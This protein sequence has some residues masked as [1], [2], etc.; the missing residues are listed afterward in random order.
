VKGCEDIYSSFDQYTEVEMLD[1]QNQYRAEG[2]GLQ[3]AQKGVSFKNFPPVLCLQLKRFEYS[4]KVDANVKLNDEYAFYPVLDLSK[5]VVEPESGTS[6]VYHLHAVL[7]HSGD[8]HGGHYYGFLRTEAKS[9]WHKFDDDHVTKATEQ[10]AIDDNF[11]GVEETELH[12]DAGRKFTNARTKFS[13]AY[14]LVYVR[15][16]DS[17]DMF[18]P[19]TQ[20]AISEHLRERFEVE[21]QLSEK[22]RKELSEA[23]LYM[24]VRLAT[25]EDFERH[26]QEKTDLVDMDTVRELRLRKS[27]TL[28]QLREKLA[29]ELNVPGERMRFWNWINRRN[30]TVRPNLPFSAAK[31]QVMLCE[32]RP[33][34][35][36]NL[37]LEVS[38]A[39]DGEPLFPPVDGHGCIFFKCFDP[40]V[41]KMR[42]LGHVCWPLT[43]EV[44]SL[45]PVVRRLLGYE[46]SVELEIYEEI[47][48]DMVEPVDS[49]QT[50]VQ[51]EL[52]SGDVL[53]LQRK[54]S[55]EDAATVLNPTAAQYY[56]WLLDR[57]QVHVRDLDQPD[58]DAF[59]LDLAKSML[60]PQVAQA[61]GARLNWNPEHLQFVPHSVA[62]Q[63]PYSKPVNRSPRADLKT[64]LQHYYA[65]ETSILYYKK[66]D[67]SLTELESKA[68][69]KVQWQNTAAQLVGAPHQ[70][71]VSKSATVADLVHALSARV[72]MTGTGR[73]RLME[74]FRHKVMTVLALTTSV[75]QLNDYMTLVAEEVA[76]EELDVAPDHGKVVQVV[77]TDRNS[78]LVQ[79]FGNP[80]MVLV[81]STDTIA[82]LRPRLQAK[83][84]VAPDEFATW[85]LAM[86]TYAR[87]DF[88]EDADVIWEELTLHGSQYL[89]LEHVDDQSA[90]RYTS[91]NW[92]RRPEHGI[93]FR[94]TDD[95]ENSNGT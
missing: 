12:L 9:R 18:E 14:M 68:T 65:A 17:R 23:H 61:V 36:L 51:A 20:D 84:G 52:G 48:P 60:Y 86:V 85:R 92:Y 11:G 79:P 6:Y 54:L 38:E 13:N 78:S 75:T 87:M 55:K 95:E 81:R 47:K 37:W 5:Y 26:D 28:S 88:L 7:V 35:A 27:S 44:H 30:K 70:L 91:G 43:T 69:F 3:D 16:T 53:V 67:M 29:K 56:H 22:R 10:E 42:Y 72:E 93:K 32:L 63:G 80:F 57:M 94:R 74:V 21:R 4:V 77:H 73:I 46:E 25:L 34:H 8:V 49:T 90:P 24:Q 19:V 76:S 89:A 71:V 15:E 45:M 33:G 39:P 83:L 82:S 50:L 59:V 64:M 58:K 2:H 66:L 40:F 41:N 31:E 1:G 62:S